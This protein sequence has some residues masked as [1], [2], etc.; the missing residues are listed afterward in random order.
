MENSKVVEQVNSNTK[1]Q[2]MMGG[3]ADAINDAVIDSLYVHQNLATQVLGKE[4]IKNRLA[5]IVYELIARGLKA[6]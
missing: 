4:R 3:F 6:S 2:A 1:E 5:D